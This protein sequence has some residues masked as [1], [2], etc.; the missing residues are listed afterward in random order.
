MPDA[1]GLRSQF[2][3]V[4]KLMSWSSGR[5]LQPFLIDNLSFLEREVGSM[6]QTLPVSE[7]MYLLGGL[8]PSKIAVSH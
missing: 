5:P 3:G 7:A 4:L 8:A 6:W 1:A 2:D